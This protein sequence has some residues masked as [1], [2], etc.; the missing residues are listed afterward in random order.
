MLAVLLVF[1]SLVL[2]VLLLLLLMM[3]VLLVLCLLIVVVVVVVLVLVV[4]LVVVAVAVVVV[5]VCTLVFCCSSC[6]YYLSC[7]VVYCF[8]PLHQVDQAGLSA[9]P[10]RKR[11]LSLLSPCLLPWPRV[12]PTLWQT[13]RRGSVPNVAVRFMADS[14]SVLSSTSFPSTVGNR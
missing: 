10:C 1:V 8:E 14:R 11:G 12:W 6:L 4:V 9:V 5:V 7:F 2:L 13:L 3:L